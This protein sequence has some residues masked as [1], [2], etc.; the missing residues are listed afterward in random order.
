M[1]LQ[2]NI[3]DIETGEENEALNKQI[4]SLFQ[5]WSRAKNCDVTGQ[6]SF[7]EIQNMIVRRLKVDGG[8]IFVKT[9]TEGGV[10]PFKLQAKEVDDLD[11]SV[12]FPYSKDSKNRIVGGIEY[13]IYNKPVAYHFKQYSPDGYYIG[14][15][16]RIEAERVIFIW[17]KHRPSQIR[18][19][20]HL[21]RTI[22]RVKELQ[23]FTEAISIKERIL[24]CLSVFITKA[25]KAVMPG[26][27]LNNNK[28]KKSGY[29]IKTIAP[30][31][32]QELEE[33][34][35]VSTVNPSGQSSDSKE[36]IAYQQRLAGAGQ[37]LSYEVVTRDMSNS[38]YSSARQ[39]MLED[40]KTYGSIQL[41]LI[42][43][44][45]KE[46]Y[47]EFLKCSVLSGKIKINNYFGNEHYYNN[48]HSWLTPGA[49]WIDPLKEAAANKTALECGFD[50]L[51]NI[52]SNRGMDW[53][54][55]I[56]QQQREIQFAEAHG[57]KIGNMGGES[58]SA[59]K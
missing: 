4:E 13:N 27:G 9:Y 57:V 7:L 40:N 21:A 6:Q 23:E 26:R 33:G 58:K 25:Q 42:D 22:N 32:I 3:K 8:I 17:F 12:E 35:T 24:A 39:S 45:Y 18:E 49:A 47:E 55:V 19:M 53:K 31:M 52:C 11:E 38:N 14:P 28:D 30:G 48:L 5:E 43:K 51:A 10:I 15:G 34:E 20:S 44:F 36:F 59:K 41:S 46:V 56:K 16:E 50:T 54:E 2:V 29:P 37:G 1:R